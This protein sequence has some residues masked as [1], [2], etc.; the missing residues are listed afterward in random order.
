MSL[1]VKCKVYKVIVLSTLLYRAETWTLYRT[2][3]K[4]L[5]SYIIMMRNLREIMKLTWEDN[6]NNEE[7]A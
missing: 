7:V 3:V 6:E 1:Q 5:S 4:K 2:Q